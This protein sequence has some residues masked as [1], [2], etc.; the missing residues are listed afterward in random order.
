MLTLKFIYIFEIRIKFSILLNLIW[1]I[2]RKK[3]NFLDT[4]FFS[5]FDA[6]PQ[7]SKKQLKKIKK[8][9]LF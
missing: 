8:S 2:S 5:F 3:I 4:F 1:H 6:E 7:L 9:A